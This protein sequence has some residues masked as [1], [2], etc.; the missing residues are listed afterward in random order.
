VSESDRADG[1]R[2]HRRGRAARAGRPGRGRAR[3]GLWRRAA[4]LLGALLL[5]LCLVAIGAVLALRWL[6][7]PTSA[8]MLE[9]RAQAW[10]AGAH[11]YRLQ[12][13]WVSLAAISP[14]TAIAVV[15]SED[16]L[17]PYNDGFDFASIREALH[18]H[19]RGARLRGAS[20]ITQQVARNLF[21]WPERSWLRK[22]L[23]AGF[24]V[25]IDTL[26]PKRRILEVYLNIAQFGP[27]I[28]GVGAAARHFFHTTPARLSR[29][30][31]ALLAAVLPNPLRLHVNAPSGYV[32]AQHDWILQQIAN[33]GGPTYLT[34]VVAR[35]A[36]LRAHNTA[37]RAP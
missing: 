18:A 12:Y 35:P 19:E 11:H 28:Y 14:Q 5:A 26:W 8:F 3:R 1:E 6:D 27:G 36:A 15:A 17:F 13:R 16:Q 20:T 10:L 33:L 25:L 31:S 4:R 32:L 30:D 29:D 22:G 37:S 9:A 21:L 24:T 2:S 7:P 23:E 34:G